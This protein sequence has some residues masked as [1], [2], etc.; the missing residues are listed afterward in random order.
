M[1]SLEAS[2]RN[3]K[4][5][6]AAWSHPPRPWRSLYESRV[7]KRL[8]RQWFISREP[9]KWSGRAV[10]RWL[11]VTH[12][13]IQKL[14]REFAT[15]SSEMERETRRHA[16]A[17]FEQLRLA[18]EETRKQ[19]DHGW[20]RPPCRWKIAEFEIGDSVARVLVPTKAEEL[21]KA[22]EASGR[23][24][25]PAYI[26]PRDLPLWA[27]GL[28]YY[29]PDYPCDPLIVTRCAMQGHQMPRARRFTRRWRPAT[30]FRP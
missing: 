26:A 12:T 16:P 1:P 29:S 17:T 6:R 9:R 27:L 25:G 24:P 14:V 10:A 18:Q 2:L 5:A 3:L 20:L 7:I 4:K 30:Q 15:D 13:Y 22:A 28:P 19:K 21:R 8:A 23:F 11:G